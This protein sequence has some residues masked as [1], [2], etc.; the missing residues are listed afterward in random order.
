L[1]L[2]ASWFKKNNGQLDR[3]FAPDKA[4]RQLVR[5]AISA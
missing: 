2:V 1:Q 4:D 5:G 3:T